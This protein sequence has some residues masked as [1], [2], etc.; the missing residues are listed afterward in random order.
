MFRK[1]ITA[2]TISAA[3]LIGVG[4]A[5]A[6]AA[7][8]ANKCVASAER[9]AAITARIAAT[10]ANITALTAARNAAQAA[11]HPRVVAR[12]NN[13]IGVATGHLAQE[14]THLATFSARCP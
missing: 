12:L 2:L 9:K 4:A 6:N 13:R 3:G 11:S 5:T 1:T 8:P 10:Q 14:Q 7:G